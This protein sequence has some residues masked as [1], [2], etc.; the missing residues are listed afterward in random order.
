MGTSRYAAVLV[1]CLGP[2][3]LA[4][5][6]PDVVIEGKQEVAH[7]DGLANPKRWGPSE[8]TVTA[9]KD[10]KANDRPTVH[11][12]M[13]VDHHGGEKKYPIGWPRMYLKLKR[14]AETDWSQ[15]ERFE[16]M[17]QAK[18]SRDKPPGRVAAFQVQCPD[19]QH[20]TYHWFQKI[21][22][23]KW[24]TVSI[25]VAKIKDVPKLARLGFN[26]SESSYKHGDKLDFYLGG[27]R[28]V[29]SADFGVKAMKLAGKAVFQGQP[30]LKLSLTVTGPPA[31]ISR[32]VPF[33]LRQGDRTLR[34]ETLPVTV[35]VQTMQIDI[36]ELKL[37]PGTYQLVAF[38]DKPGQRKAVEFRV[39]ATPWEP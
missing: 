26:I 36:S 2:A 5:G 20:V 24:L 7:L 32:G 6:A 9:S 17:F 39:V 27:F 10:L 14:P 23:G 15:F 29:R 21:E 4:A 37:K 1:L 13:S 33:A 12:H 34:K 18:M 11:V 16:F 28:L 35:G 30:K 31:K 22:L 25:P 19:R 8:C 38:E 3:V